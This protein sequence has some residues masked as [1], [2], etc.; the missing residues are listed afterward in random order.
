M[1]VAILVIGAVALYVYVTQPYLEYREQR[2][3]SAAETIKVIYVSFACGDFYPRLSEVTGTVDGDVRNSEISTT[4]ALPA[5]VPSPEDTDLGVGGNIFELTGYRYRAEET[6]ILTRTVREA[7]STRFDVVAWQVQ[8]P[9][10]VWVTSGTGGTPK[11][12]ER[13]EPVRHAMSGT[14]SGPDSFVLRRYD[15]CP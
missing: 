14:N 2:I 1:I 10:R 13:L 12:A 15:P 4:L 8:V 5:G 7:P 3:S 6:N 11:K 9:Y